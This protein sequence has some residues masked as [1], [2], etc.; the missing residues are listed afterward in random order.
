MPHLLKW[1]ASPAHVFLLCLP[2]SLPACHAHRRPARHISSN[3]RTDA[4]HTQM[5][6]VHAVMASKSPALVASPPPSAAAPLH[7]LRAAALSTLSAALGGDDLAAE[8]VLLASLS[9]VAGR[10][11][12]AVL[13]TVPLALTSVPTPGQA[14][15]RP[16][17]GRAGVALSAAL[18]ALHPLTRRL[19]LTVEAANAGGWAPAR[20]AGALRVSQSP[21]AV[22]PGT[23]LLVDETE[24]A[25]GKFDE[26]GYKNLQALAGV[27][28]AQQLRCGGCAGGAAAEMWR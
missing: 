10:V 14:G 3:L 18:A 9:R 15:A 24:L 21:L 11:D 6:C 12:G 23:V 17:S 5:V 19:L 27:L 22:P 2:A 25:A 8:Y 4:A 1:C 20:K 26:A 13:G 16:G 28:A 7:M